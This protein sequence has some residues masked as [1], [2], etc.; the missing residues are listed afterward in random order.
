MT[1]YFT[2]EAR[3]DVRSST[4]R[5]YTHGCVRN[6][7]IGSAHTSLA[8]AQRATGPQYSDWHIE[9]LIEV[10]AAEARAIAKARDNLKLV[11]VS[12]K[13]EGKSTSA[14]LSREHFGAGAVARIVTGS[15]RHWIGESFKPG[16]VTIDFFPVNDPRALTWEPSKG[17]ENFYDGMT[18][19]VVPAR[20]SDC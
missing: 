14:K 15:H 10:T 7:V 6:G 19:S 1:R 3:A 18:V 13:Y 12:V 20:V 8:L 11:R 9:P 4:G 16:Y 17:C 5:L 2:T